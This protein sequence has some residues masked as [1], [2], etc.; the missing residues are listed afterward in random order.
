MTCPICQPYHDDLEDAE[1]YLCRLRFFLG[2]E[3][4]VDMKERA[5]QQ[6]EIGAEIERVNKWCDD[7]QA[8][9]REH[10]CVVQLALFED[11][12]SEITERR[13]GSF[14]PS[15]SGSLRVL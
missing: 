8:W 3:L 1:R 10:R 5:R 9:L 13:S 7:A 2:N 14:R 12:A 11:A 15:I 6:K 4:S